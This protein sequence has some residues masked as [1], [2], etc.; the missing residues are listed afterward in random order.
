[1]LVVDT[2][3]EILVFWTIMGIFDVC[4]GPTVGGLTVPVFKPIAFSHLEFLLCYLVLDRLNLVSG[5][6]KSLIELYEGLRDL[7]VELGLVNVVDFNVEGD[8]DAEV[9]DIFL[10]NVAMPLQLNE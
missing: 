9:E 3:Q 5:L 7:V 10:L 4:S 6:F 8:G 1:M 2:C